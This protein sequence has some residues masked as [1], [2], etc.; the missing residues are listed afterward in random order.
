MI[1]KRPTKSTPESGSHSLDSIATA[2]LSESFDSLPLHHETPDTSP[3]K[4]EAGYRKF[5]ERQK[6]RLNVPSPKMKT[7]RREVV[8]NTTDKPYRVGNSHVWENVSFEEF[9]KWDA[10]RSTLI[11]DDRKA[12]AFD[13]D[14]ELGRL[15]IRLVDGYIHDGLIAMVSDE[16][17]FVVRTE[18]LSSRVAHGHTPSKSSQLINVCWSTGRSGNGQLLTSLQL[19]CSTMNQSAKHLIHV[20]GRN[21]PP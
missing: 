11:T 4:A 15:V 19:S 3:E 21:G 13:Y 6:L 5:P 7:L 17:A 18:K 2:P 1:P 10:G 9:S 16:I 14:T 8:P 20:S 12:S